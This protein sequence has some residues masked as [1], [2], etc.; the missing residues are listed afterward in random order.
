MLSDQRKRKDNIV[1]QREKTKELIR[2][3]ILKVSGVSKIA[4]V[5]KNRKMVKEAV[6]GNIAK[7]KKIQRIESILL[8]P[9]SKRSAEQLS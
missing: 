6:G 2:H 8:T 1:L 3:N 9:P 5:L 7:A 4:S